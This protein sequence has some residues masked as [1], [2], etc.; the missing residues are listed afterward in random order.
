[1]SVALT[2]LL[3]LPDLKS[4]LSRAHEEMNPEHVLS[5]LRRVP[6]TDCELLDLDP[7][8]GRPENLVMTHIAVP[9]ACIRPSVNMEEGG[10]SNEDD[11]TM[12]MSN[13]V[14]VCPRRLFRTP[15]C[16]PLVRR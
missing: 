2:L 4:H 12:C 5:L 15:S 16:G 6:D 14:K 9:P 1:M 11:L 13:L 3:Q 10:S 8:H 7:R